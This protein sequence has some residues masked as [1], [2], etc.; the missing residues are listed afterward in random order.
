MTA[1]VRGKL[2]F[3][4]AML[5]VALAPACGG[6]S[7]DGDGTDAGFADAEES[8]AEGKVR[9]DIQMLDVGLLKGHAY[10]DAAEGWHAASIKV[11]AIDPKEI[12]W[13]VID[14][15]TVGVPGSNG[16]QFFEVVLQELPR[17]DQIAVTATV[18]FESDGGERVE[19]T[20]S[21]AWPP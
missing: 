8:Y 17:G 4:L 14:A 7:E 10:A 1:V 3:A 2:L 13:L 15:N 12:R 20:A 6:D 9:I 18:E 5:A 11:K 19:R 21:D 16:D